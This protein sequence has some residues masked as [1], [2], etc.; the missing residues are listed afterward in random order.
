MLKTLI[1]ILIMIGGIAICAAGYWLGIVL[2]AVMGALTIVGGVLTVAFLIGYG[3][4]E[5]LT[6]KWKKKP[7]DQ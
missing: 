2:A 7:P 5:S 1:G 3:I 4:Y 6:E